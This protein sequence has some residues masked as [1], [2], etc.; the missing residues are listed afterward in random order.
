MS[1]RDFV[2]KHDTPLAIAWFLGLCVLWFVFALE[3]EASYPKLHEFG[4]RHWTVTCQNEARSY[5]LHSENLSG[6]RS[7]PS[8]I[9]RHLSILNEHGEELYYTA[10][11]N[12]DRYERN[13]VWAFTVGRD[14]RLFDGS[15]SSEVLYGDEAV[16]AIH[17]RFDALTV[18]TE[19]GSR[20]VLPCRQG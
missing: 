19:N 2:H 7:G 20:L 16:F 18:V 4:I 15:R 8:V 13:S 11:F 10:R 14:S 12:P 9:Q 17:A 6:W 1:I 3:Q 5:R